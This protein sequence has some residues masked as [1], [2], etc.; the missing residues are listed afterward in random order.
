MS[1]S[2]QKFLSNIKA[3]DGLARPN[4]FE[5][6]LPIPPYINKF[7]S[8]TVLDELLNFRQTLVAEFLDA[9]RNSN[10]SDEQSRSANPSV[11]RFL[12]LQCEATELPGRSLLTA[13]VETYGPVYKIPYQTQYADISLTFLCT[14]DFYERKLFDRWIEATMPRDTFNM[15]FPKD[16]ETRYM[17]NIKIIQY[18]EIIKQIYAIELLDA[19]PTSIASQGLNWADDGFHR[20]SVQFS[21]W[22]Y[23]TV[24]TGAYD[25]AQV[26]LALLDRL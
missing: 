10:L 7:V 18:D 16:E 3:R 5:V 24:Y 4:R 2:P 17:T 8:R 19:F 21:Y 26:A 25:P 20:L 12:T 23:R 15:R 11:S 22:K 14:N 9:A 6:I 1:F 13:D